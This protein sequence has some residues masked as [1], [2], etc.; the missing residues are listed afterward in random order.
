[1]I[2][3]DTAVNPFLQMMYYK[4]SYKTWVKAMR[5]A[6]L[7]LAPFEGMLLIKISIIDDI[8]MKKSNLFQLVLK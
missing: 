5:S 6:G 2:G 8:T 3:T 7:L 1:M 4:I